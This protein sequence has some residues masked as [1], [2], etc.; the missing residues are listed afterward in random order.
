MSP[1]DALIIG[2]ETQPSCSASDLDGV[3]NDITGP[4]GKKKQKIARTLHGN[5]QGSRKYG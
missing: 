3:E 1:P 5:A 2:F 4:L